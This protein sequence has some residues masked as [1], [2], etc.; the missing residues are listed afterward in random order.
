MASGGAIDVG[1]QEARLQAQMPIQQTPEPA[2]G[3]H[4]WRRR[5]QQLGHDEKSTS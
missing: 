1:R 2:Q 4:G 3:E 5:T